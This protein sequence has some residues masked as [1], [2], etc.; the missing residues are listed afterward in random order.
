MT[1]ITRATKKDAALLCEIATQTFIASHGHSASEADINNYIAE[2]YSMAAITEELDDT[3]NIYH[4]I[5]YNDIPA[6]YSKIIFD[7]PYAGSEKQHITKLDRIYLLPRFYDLSL[8]KI[9]LQ[10][11]IDLAKKNQQAGIWLFVWTANERAVNFYSKNGF[12]I[13]GS[14]NFKIS[15]NHSNPNHQ[16]L[17]EF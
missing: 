3:K 6:G 1:T 12:V 16:M 8:G 13:I 15:A 11:N 2:K 14:H 17:L 5:Y 10:F 7:A 4:I 9:L